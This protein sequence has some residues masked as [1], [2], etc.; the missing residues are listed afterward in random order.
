MFSGSYVA[1][2][3][4]FN[5]DGSVNYDKFAELI[6]WQI[7]QGTNGIL[8]RG[9]TGEASTLTDEEHLELIR[10]AVKAVN[11]RVPLV[12]GTGSNDTLYSLYLSQGAEEAGVDAVLLI[13]PY[14]LKTNEEGLYQHFA[15]VADRI[16]T[17]IILYNVPS[18]TTMNISI[19]VLKRLSE[20][21]NIV[22]IK[23]AHPETGRLLQVA[24]ECPSLKMFS[25]NDNAIVPTM[26]LGGVGVISVA[27]NLIP[28]VVSQICSLYASGN[29]AEASKLQIKYGRLIDMLFIEPNPIPIKEAMNLIGMN[30]GGYRLPLVQMQSSNREKLLAE[31]KNLNLL[32]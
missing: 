1:L 32:S 5:N 14:Y 11:H 23:E 15:Y 21:K 19:N 6:D 26:S 28:N 9:T 30:V 31:M 4:P 27:A 29:T 17:P 12:A 8:V 7:E 16:K 25:G 2:V 18:R 10:F 24:Y 13:T 22:A 3:T 20:H